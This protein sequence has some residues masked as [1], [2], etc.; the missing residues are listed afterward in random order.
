MRVVFVLKAT[1]LI[2]DRSEATVMILMLMKS[3]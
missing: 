1:V 3:E 2:V